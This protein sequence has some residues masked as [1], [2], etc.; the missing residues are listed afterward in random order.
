M[1]IGF[2]LGAF[3]AGKLVV[4]MAR[5]EDIE[6]IQGHWIQFKII[7]EKREA[8]SKGYKLGK[9]S[10]IGLNKSGCV[11]VFDEGDNIIEPCNAHKVWKEKK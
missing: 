4:G 1:F 8:F 9:N 10:R 11:C 7:K 5:R 6:N 3:L 2:S